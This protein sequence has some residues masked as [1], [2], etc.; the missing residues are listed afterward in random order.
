[1]ESFQPTYKGLKLFAPRSGK[2]TLPCFQPTYK[3]LKRDC[4]SFHLNFCSCFQP[5]YKGLKPFIQNVVGEG[6]Y[7]FLAYL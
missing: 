7:Q 6:L 2:T 5:T 1:M 4:F 3:G